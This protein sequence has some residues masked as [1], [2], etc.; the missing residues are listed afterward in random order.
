MHIVVNCIYFQKHNHSITVTQTFIIEVF[1]K[2]VQQ[3]PHHQFTFLVTESFKSVFTE[4]S[5]VTSIIINEKKSVVE[6]IFF[7]EFQLP[8]LLKKIKANIII[9]PF[10]KINN[11]NC[12]QVLFIENPYQQKISANKIQKA[13]LI[14]TFSKANLQMIEIQKNAEGKV[15][16]VHPVAKRQTTI[17]SLQEQSIIKENYTS[18]SSFFLATSNTIDEVLLILKAFSI[19]KKRMQSN[20]H[21]IFYGEDTINK[22]LAEKIKQ[23]KY[24][25]SINLISYSEEIHF[26]NLLQAS[27][28]Y[29]DVSVLPTISQNIFNA[30]QTNTPVIAAE[31]INNSE[32]FQNFV[33]ILTS[34]TPEA[35]ANCLNLLY[36]DE[37]YRN[38]LIVQNTNA[39]E[40]YN[41]E[42]AAKS[43]WAILQNNFTGL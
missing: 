35:I 3:Q 17:L 5:N 32:L 18:G 15:I 20:M 21:F 1:C 42:N 26:E 7:Y 29:V 4:A 6:R 27:Y 10:N 22:R 41:T 16:V 37:V 24:R 33:L 12:F 36:K 31:H 2:L 30:F 28:A 34:V 19:F 13:K 38:K 40:I 8:Q 9:E 25:H 39:M 14:V 11:T 43:F 23:Y